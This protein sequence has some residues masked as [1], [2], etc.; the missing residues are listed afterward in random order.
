M[1]QALLDDL[2]VGADLDHQSGGRVPESVECEAVETGSSNRWP[3]DPVAKVGDS[4]RSALGCL[5][6]VVR[7]RDVH[8]GCEVFG[9][10]VD[11]KWRNAERA[12]AGRRLH[13]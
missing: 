5:E 7:R 13:F 1:P 8:P 6:Q 3:P 4:H 11:E 9:E 10:Q 2:D 12:P